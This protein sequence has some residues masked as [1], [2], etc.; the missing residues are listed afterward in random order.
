MEYVTSLYKQWSTQFINIHVVYVYNC[1]FRDVSLYWE[2]RGVYFKTLEWGVNQMQ[3][4]VYCI[5]NKRRLVKNC[6]AY[7]LLKTSVHAIHIKLY[8]KHALCIVVKQLI[9]IC[10]IHMTFVY[11]VH[12]MHIKLYMYNKHD[13]YIVVKTFMWSCTINMP[14]V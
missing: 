3:K 11:S 5:W 8:N 13:I 14:F 9:Q 4:Y 12:A 6:P 1:S 10:T 2:L 7:K